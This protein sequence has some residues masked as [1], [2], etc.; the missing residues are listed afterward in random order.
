MFCKTDTFL[1]SMFASSQNS[2]L[3]QVKIWQQGVVKGSLPFC[4]M[5]TG[6]VC[7]YE[8]VHS[9]RRKESSCS[10]TLQRTPTMVDL[11]LQQNRPTAKQRRLVINCRLRAIVF[12][13]LQHCRFVNLLL[14][15]EQ[16]LSIFCPLLSMIAT[17]TYTWRKY[18]CYLILE[19][20][21][22]WEVPHH[23]V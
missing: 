14:F 8:M 9:Q 17:A 4:Y 10:W 18:K 2:T 7:W 1:S 12:S 22:R 3:F 16:Y 21:F 6:T 23:T 5:I 19:Y 15:L 13:C 20:N 11:Q